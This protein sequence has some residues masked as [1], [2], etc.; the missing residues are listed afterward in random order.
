MDAGTGGGLPAIPLAILFPDSKF[1]P[2]DSVRKKIKVVKAIAEKLELKNIDPIA[3]RIE[4]IDKKFDFIIS[5]AVTSLPPFYSYV[6]NKI[7]RK[8]RNTIPN[9]IL[10]LKG[11]DFNDELKEVKAKHKLYEISDFF[12]E[13]YFQTKK[14]VHL[15]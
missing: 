6:K 9:G 14:L 10:Y 4:N 7:S 15:F 5:R 3:D 12:S 13:E 2:V 1:L 11:G 8:S